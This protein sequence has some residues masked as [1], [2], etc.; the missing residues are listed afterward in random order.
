MKRRQLWLANG[1]LALAATALSVA[2]MELGVR[3]FAPQPVAV[4][5]QDRYGL[6]MHWPGLIAYLPQFGMTASFNSAGMR[7]REHGYEKP[8]GVF[9]VL[10]LG[11]SFMEALQVPFE[12]SLP[13]LLER[14]L[15]QQT[16][17]TIE[18]INAGTSGWGT[19]DELR[20]LTSYGLRWKPDLVLVAMTL[21]N[22]VS[23][24]LREEWHTLHNG[25]LVEQPR[26]QASSLRY[27][28]IRF[29]AF[30][31]TRLQIYQLW[32][33]V[34]HG[35]ELQ[36]VGTDLNRHIIDLC[37]EPTPPRIAR[38]IELTER[39]LDRIRTV[40]AAEGGRVVLALLPLRVQTSD[41]LFAQF[42]QSANAA[43]QEMKL[44]KPQQLIGPSAEGLGIPVI[45]LLQPFRQ[46]T[47]DSTGALYIESD[48]HWTEAGHRLATGVVANELIQRGLVR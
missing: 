1:L 20:Y 32:R 2:F 45:N 10:V 13:S 18:V 9:R 28:I 37:R 17:K 39:L 43:T 22:D 5:L 41:Q 3:L 38:G 42:V 40:V 8:P 34:W 25:A 27:A 15:H 33:K 23:D 24:N 30:I 12:S 19:D 11:D 35:G 29:K 14:A 7:D 21:H 31:S 46:W 48:G 26:M 16:G 6:A 44:D 4:S 47:A 36:Q